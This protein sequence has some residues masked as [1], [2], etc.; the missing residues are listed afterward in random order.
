M[1]IWSL[2]QFI[3]PKSRT[4][5]CKINHVYFPSDL[6]WKLAPNDPQWN[7][8]WFPTW[9]GWCEAIS[10]HD[11]PSRWCTGSSGAPV[12]HQLSG[13]ADGMTAEALDKANNFRQDKN[14]LGF[15]PTRIYLCKASKS[16]VVLTPLL[17][18]SLLF[19]GIRRGSN[20]L[21][22]GR[23]FLQQCP[24]G[25]K[26]HELLEIHPKTFLW[27]SRVFLISVPDPRGL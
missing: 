19:S 24:G 17:C 26:S 22:Q 16:S 5:L 12:C 4:E 14:R 6:P 13:S 25:E 27:S 10:H 23:A 11:K 9:T 7:C 20:K 15:Y 21:A 8:V 18:A 3:V 2:L 1:W